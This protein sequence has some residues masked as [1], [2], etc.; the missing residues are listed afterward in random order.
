MLDVQ[1]FMGCLIVNG[2]GCLDVVSSRIDIQHRIV[3]QISTNAKFPCFKKVGYKTG[4]LLCKAWMC[5]TRNKSQSFMAYVPMDLW[6]SLG[7]MPLERKNL[8]D[9]FV[10]YCLCCIDHSTC[11]CNVFQ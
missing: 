4:F 9:L 5:S 10:E 6:L 11:C 7:N 2:I 3:V 8:Y 1:P